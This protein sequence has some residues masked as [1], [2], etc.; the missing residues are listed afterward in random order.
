[1]SNSPNPP[2][3]GNFIWRW[4]KRLLLAFVLILVLLVATFFAWRA[5]ASHRVAVSLTAI[6]AA[7]Y[8]K[9][10][11]ELE[12]KWY[13]PIPAADNAALYYIK[14][15]TPL[16]STNGFGSS[17]PFWT[18]S[19]LAEDSVLLSSQG[20][21]KLLSVFT[22]NQEVLKSLRN[23][24]P[25][26]QSRY[27]ID[28]VNGL[29]DAKP[30]LSKVGDGVRLL[31]LSAVFN[32]ET[33]KS[34]DAITDLIAALQLSASTA[35]EPSLVSQLT[36]C[37][38][39]HMNTASLERI[40]KFNHPTDEQLRALAAEFNRL[41]SPDGMEH[42]LAFERCFGLWAF[43]P[44][45]ASLGSQ[46][47]GIKKGREFANNLMKKT[48]Y[49][50]NDL[51]YYLAVMQKHVAASK[52]P[53]PERLRVVKQIDENHFN[54]G[55][56]KLH[57]LSTLMLVSYEKAHE[58]YATA[59]A[60]QNIV[61]TV[62][63]IERYRLAQPGQIPDSLTTLI[64]SFIP[65]LPTDPFDG[66]SLKLK[67]LNQGY[68][69]YSIGPDEVDDGGKKYQLDSKSYDLTFSVER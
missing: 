44:E 66:K 2:A 64:P 12:D 56:G 5:W 32:G 15:L 13:A 10:F 55:A 16:T 58:G 45:I 1:M 27:P 43:G 35:D 11:Q 67:K 6:Q 41:K 20:R 21:N 60:D 9:T 8:P 25:Q 61:Q 39:I 29:P 34:Q 62:L 63:A 17:L 18:N 26:Q 68:M 23:A 4:F 22:R 69:V 7:G 36:L 46:D 59:L 54:K 65:S 33:G 52:L 24:P 47:P 14:A 28:F 30:H 40:L 37:Q 51:A 19:Q 31:L 53:F 38:L 3:Q 49:H 50:D 48:G 42:A 57:L